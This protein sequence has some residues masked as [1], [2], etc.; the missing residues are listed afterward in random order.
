MNFFEA[1][2]IIL[3]EKVHRVCVWSLFL[4]KI[5]QY[6]I[7]TLISCDRERVREKGMKIQF[8][9]L[10]PRPFISTRSISFI[11]ILPPRYFSSFLYIHNL[12]RYWEGIFQQ[13]SLLLHHI[14]IA[15][16]KW[17]EWREMNEGRDVDASY[18]IYIQS[19]CKCPEIYLQ[20][21]LTFFLSLFFVFFDPLQASLALILID[22][23][24][25]FQ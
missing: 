22:T 11:L 17:E 20:F 1:E 13:F 8:I 14:T 12:M 24:K 2:K 19:N 21:F 16:R 25:L 9:F 15:F 18:E 5:S 10:W 23:F 7:Y 6:C 4:H 3:V